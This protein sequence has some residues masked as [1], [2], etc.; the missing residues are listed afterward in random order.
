MANGGS[1]R[2]GRIPAY[3]LGPT[4]LGRETETADLMRRVAAGRTR[5]AVL[6]VEGEPGVGKSTLLD[7]AVRRTRGAAGH[8]VLRAVGS[9]SAVV[10]CPVQPWSAE[11]RASSTTRRLLGRTHEGN[12]HRP[13]LAPPPPYRTMV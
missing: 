5:S 8:R 1:T 4:V 3:D 12:P 9:E 11:T 7:L 6:V 13:R 10:R 2:A